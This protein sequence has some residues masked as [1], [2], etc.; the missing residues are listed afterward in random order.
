MRTLTHRTVALALAIIL[1]VSPVVL[2]AP[3][4]VGNVMPLHNEAGQNFCTAFQINER[5]GLW[6][7]AGHCIVAAMKRGMK[8][9][10][11]GKDVML[12]DIGFDENR[13]FAVLEVHGIRASQ[14]KLAKS[15]PVRG[16]RATIA[17][18]PY[19]W[20]VLTITSGHVAARLVPLGQVPI[21]DIY[22]ITI[23]GGNSGSPVLNANGE[24]IGLLWG[25][26]NEAMHGLGIP[27]ESLKRDIGKYFG[28]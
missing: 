9:M 11:A 16:D 17:G 14:L 3:V 21:S 8:V 27:W 13:D 25:G 5:D 6:A 12:I 26:M 20:P 24:V 22:D 10:I 1:L 15:A 4:R 18:Y 23:A 2:A 7:T 19:G 28:R